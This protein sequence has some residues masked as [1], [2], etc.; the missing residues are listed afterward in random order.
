MYN[1]CQ[2][3]TH[4]AANKHTAACAGQEVWCE[5]KLKCPIYFQ[6]KNSDVP[7]IACFSYIENYALVF[8]GVWVRIGN[9]ETSHAYES[10]PKD[11]ST[12]MCVLERDRGL[13]EI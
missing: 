12:R 4:N 8:I 9:W 1:L 10:S 3:V 7:F 5:E 6:N 11:G 13:T 2:M